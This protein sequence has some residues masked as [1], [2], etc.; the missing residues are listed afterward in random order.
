[1]KRIR[2]NIG[3]ALLLAAAGMN[4]PLAH[5]TAAA[6]SMSAQVHRTYNRKERR[7]ARHRK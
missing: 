5:E 6:N 4:G 1:M 7:A 2:M 3:A